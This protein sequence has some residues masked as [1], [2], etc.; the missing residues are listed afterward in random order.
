MRMDEAEGLADRPLEEPQV[1]HARR[2]LPHESLTVGGMKQG[3]HTGG[4]N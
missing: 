4:D 2:D 1:F 3:A